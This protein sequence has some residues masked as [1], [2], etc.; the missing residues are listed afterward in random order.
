[1]LCYTLSKIAKQYDTTVAELAELNNIQ[2]VNIIS[3]GQIIKIPKNDISTKPKDKPEVIAPNSGSSVSSGAMHEAHPSW[4]FEAYYTGVDFNS[5]IDKEMSKGHVCTPEAKYGCNPPWRDPQFEYDK[6]YYAASREAV[7]YFMDPRNFLNDT[8]VFQFMSANYDSAT[9]NIDA[10]NKVLSG[11][12]LADYASTFLSAGGQEVSAAFLAAKSRVE[13]G[14]GTSALATGTVE[15]YEGYYNLYGL[16]AYDGNAGV[17][18]AKFAKNRGWNTTEL[19]I[20]CGA[21]YIDEKYVDK[22]QDTLYTMKWNIDAFKSSGNVSGQ[23]ATHIKDA[24]N[25]ADSFAKGL[26][27]IDAPICFRIP[28]YNE[29]PDTPLA[30]PK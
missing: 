12:A 7:S 9:Q 29:M 16:G 10:V 1:L 3:V 26:K 25:K 6:G 8:Y 5:F 28:V 4:K 19:G 22:G 27:N 30:E 13:T 24:Y 18:G 14:G 23:Y 21:E 20:T 17:A 15:N 11:T 2:N